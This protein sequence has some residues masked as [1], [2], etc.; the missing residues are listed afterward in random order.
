MPS[1]Y[2][3]MIS[4]PKDFPFTTTGVFLADMNLLIT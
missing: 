3:K 4:F 2:N 1:K